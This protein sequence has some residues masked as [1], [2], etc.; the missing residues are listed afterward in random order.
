MSTLDD[1]EIEILKIDQT[2]GGELVIS[3]DAAL[4]D[5]YGEPIEGVDNTS[6][7][8]RLSLTR[9]Q[10]DIL[11]DYDN[12]AVVYF[13]ED[14]NE[15]ERLA[16]ELRAE[17]DIYW[18]E[19]KTTHLSTYGII[20]IDYEPEENGVVVA[21]T[22]KTITPDTGTMTAAGASASIAAMAAAVTVGMLTSIVSFTYLM[23]R[24]G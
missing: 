5:R 18:A 8:I 13:N 11:C 14:G 21:E 9:E 10:Y 15:A 12:V 20:G 19:F 3:F 22:S 16:V 7:I 17:G 23:R 24:R 6:I 1:D 4:W 2:L